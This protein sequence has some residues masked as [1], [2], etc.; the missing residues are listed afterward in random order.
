MAALIALLLSALAVQ[1]ADGAPARSVAVSQEAVEAA[2]SQAGD[3][4]PA[5]ESSWP[6][7]ALR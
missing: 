4:R 7:R 1:P 5:L 2:L 3:H 6:R